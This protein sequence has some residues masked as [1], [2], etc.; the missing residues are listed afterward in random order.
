[1][2]RFFLNRGV[3]SGTVVAQ[4]QHRPVQPALPRRRRRRD[5]RDAS[6]PRST[7]STR[8]NRW[9]IFLVHTIS[10][11]SQSWYAPI[12]I[13]V[14]TDS[15]AH[16]KSLGDVWIDSMVNVGAY[17]RGQK[18]LS[19]VTPAAAGGGQTWTWT[20]PTH[21]PPRQGPAHHR[22]R[23]HAVAERHA[24]DLGSARLLRDRAGRGIADAV[25]VTHMRPRMTK[26]I[27][28]AM[29]AAAGALG[30]RQRSELRRARRDAAAERRHAAPGR[31]RRQQPGAAAGAASSRRASLGRPRGYDVGARRTRAS[32]GRAAGSW[33][34]FEG[35]SLSAALTIT[36]TA[37]IFKAVV[38]GTPQAPFTAPPGTTTFMLASGPRRRRS[39]RRALPPDRGS[40]GRVAPVLAHVGDGTLM[41]PP[42]GASRLIE[43]DRR[44]DHLR[45]R[46]PRRARRQRLLPDREPL[47]HVRGDRGARARRRGQHDRGVGPRH[48]PQL[49][50][51]HE[52]HD[53]DALPARGHER[54]DA[55]SGTSTSSRRRSSST[56]ARTTSATARAIPATP[57]ATPT[58]RCSRP[59]APYYPHT[60]IVCIIAPLLNGGD[61][62]HDR[63]PHQGR[64]R[65]APRRRRH[66]RRVL[67]SDPGPD[68]GQVRLPVPPERRRE[69]DD[70]GPAGRRAEGQARLVSARIGRPRSP[71]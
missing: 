7:T 70:G 61:L 46:H 59:C 32:P 49:R 65:R 62:D 25:T 64:R 11:T 38:D 42:A 43:F 48:R 35:T 21:F 18:L 47:G 28:I 68:G 1:M 67:Q 33:R 45:L 41:D 54:R 15:V 14:I 27:L 56:W 66:E 53:A 3:A 57:S 19:A 26:R 8:R 16:A 9:A 44:F 30:L 31:R 69:H 24:A 29:A 39:H 71:S 52:R 6:T 22:R 34:A 20:L 37:A 58:G 51:R 2:S 13:S 50:R 17:W 60:V 40:A 23:R 36:G 10:P 5:G 55:R 4:R 63:A 12:D